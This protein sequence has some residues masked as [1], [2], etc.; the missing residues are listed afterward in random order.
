[1]RH[2]LPAAVFADDLNV[3]T[4]EKR[5]LEVQANKISAYATWARMIVNM[6]KSRVTGARYRSLPNT[7]FH[8]PSL[9]LRLAGVRI[10]GRA[11]E[12]SPPTEPFRFLGVTLTMD[13][14]WA[15]HTADVLKKLKDKAAAL[16]GSHLSAWRKGLV[17]QRAV[18][19]AVEYGLALCPFGALETAKID[20]VLAG[21]AK[22]T[23]GL[24]RY[25]A[26]A[27]AHTP[28]AKG[29]LGLASVYASTAYAA[30]RSLTRAIA[31]AGRRGAW[32]RAL[33][34]KALQL[35]KEGK[36]LPSLHRY[37]L[38]MRQLHAAAAA[39]IR[40]EWEQ[41][42]ADQEPLATEL[43]KWQ[44]GMGHAPTEGAAAAA[45]RVFER[46]STADLR[47]LFEAGATSARWLF[48]A[49]KKR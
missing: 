3:L 22:Q 46:E 36:R 43:K 30:G 35:A 23:S 15:P 33:L 9:A 44:T 48:D 34:V 13:L 45:Y 42:P 14:N 32:A 12:F 47:T 28:K 19:T 17:L 26:N 20:A 41:V 21:I 25:T 29:G 27:W 6:A 37:S 7:P 31:D 40:W 49:H 4:T 39:G 2:T 16:Q 1:M 18:K 5:D 24:P 38:R 11:V 10:N 8:A